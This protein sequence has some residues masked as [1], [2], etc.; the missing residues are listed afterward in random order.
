[1]MP[2][3]STVQVAGPGFRVPFWRQF[4]VGWTQELG[5][6]VTLAVDGIAARGERLMGIVDYNPL[7]PALGPGRRPDDAESRPGT[8]TSVFQF[9]SYGRSWYRGLAL[10][11][12]KRMSHCFE[13][14]VS[15]TLSNAED[16]VSDTFGQ[17]NVAEGP[18]YGRDP[19]DA[20]GRPL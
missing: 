14:L 1:M 6:S 10:S 7:V 17:A 13:G 15:Y 9:T 8:S 4:S 5:R 11:L 3:P 18:G 20:A 12:R 16:T 2:F 19:L